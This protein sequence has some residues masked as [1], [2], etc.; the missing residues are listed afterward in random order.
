M[1]AW[2]VDAV[3]QRHGEVPPDELALH[4]DK[5]MLGPVSGLDKDLPKYGAAAHCG[6]LDRIEVDDPTYVRAYVATVDKR[7]LLIMQIDVA[8]SKMTYLRFDPAH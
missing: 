3:T 7:W 1:L 2:F 8:T 5:K 6:W 4:A